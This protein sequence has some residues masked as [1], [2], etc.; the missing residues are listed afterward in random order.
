MDWRR[1]DNGV[2]MMGGEAAEEEETVPHVL[3][4]EGL[5]RKIRNLRAGTEQRMNPLERVRKKDDCS[6]V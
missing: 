6:R 5:V 2:L 4:K 3:R 1:E